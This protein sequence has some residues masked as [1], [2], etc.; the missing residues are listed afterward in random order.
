[1]ELEMLEPSLFLGADTG[2]PARFA[3]AVAALAAPSRRAA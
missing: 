2:A 3:R 1:M